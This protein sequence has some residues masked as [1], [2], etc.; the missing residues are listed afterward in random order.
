MNEI[1]KRKI[2]IEYYET[3][4][5]ILQFELNK[6]SRDLSEK[7]LNLLLDIFG[8]TD[9][10]NEI[11]QSVEAAECLRTSSDAVLMVADGVN[12]SEPTLEIKAGFVRKLEIENP[13]YFDLPILYIRTEQA[14]LGGK[15]YSCKLLACMKWLGIGT[16]ED[17]TAALEIWR[18]LAANGDAAAIS[19]VIYAC[20][21]LGNT[22]EKKKWEKVQEKLREADNSFRPMVFDS[23]PD[24]DAT[25]LANLILAARGRQN[26]EGNT[27]RAIAYYILYSDDCFEDKLKAVSSVRDFSP[28]LWES[29]KHGRKKVGF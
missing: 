10:E 26:D 18:T 5:G 3:V 11:L 16:A 25:K 21:A 20:G 22:V 28:V 13:K 2:L 9:E 29:Y 7:I 6:E 15:K 27:D 8:E 1:T 19:A 4:S 14:A 12:A 24:D 23:E 17:R